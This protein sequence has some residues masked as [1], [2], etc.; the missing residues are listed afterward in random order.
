MDRDAEKKLRKQLVALLESSEA[1]L[2]LEE[3]LADWPVRLRG[4]KPE[5]AS[6]TA[7]Q[8]LEHLR[9]AQWDII[10]FCRNPNHVSPEF[11]G[12]YWPPTPAPPDKDAWEQS[13]RQIR[14]DLRAMQAMVADPGNDLFAR[15]NH[16]EAHAK[17]TL[18]REALLLADHNAYHL[19]QLVQLR[20]LL[21]H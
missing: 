2:A 19:G 13:V 18:L 3:V 4:V 11:P 16:P 14:A 9:I 6:H 7:W 12:Q 8:L 10:E 20:R 17:H 1:H 15:I 5:G 21:E